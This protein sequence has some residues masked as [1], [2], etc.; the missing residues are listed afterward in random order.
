M[1]HVIPSLSPRDGGPSEAV[2]RMTSEL[3][4]GGVDVLVA[5]TDAD[6]A[7]RLPVRLGSVERRDGIPAI[8]FP[9]RFPGSFKYSGGLRRWLSEH[10]ADFDAVHVHAVFS[11]SSL[12]AGRACRR[13]GVPYLVRPLGSLEAWSLRQK[14]VRKRFALAL[15]VRRLLAGAAAVHYTTGRERRESE[16]ALRL[17]NGIV[18]PLGIERA[19]ARADGAREG[20]PYVL[21]LSRLHPKK[22][23]EILIDAFETISAE[24]RFRDWTL[25]IAGDGDP[26]YAASLR[27]RAA[28]TSGRDRVHFAGWLSGEEKWR[29]VAQADL[30][31][32]PSAEEN[33]GLAVLE[34]MGAGVPVAVS[35]G[36]D[37]AEEVRS[38]EAGWVFERSAPSLVWTLRQALSRPAERRRRGLRGRG[39]VERS[40]LWPEIANRLVETYRSIR[41]TGRPPQDLAGSPAGGAS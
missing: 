36:V 41:E 31:V 23:V 19:E 3:Q 11:H 38:A 33:F 5:A 7:G 17:S 29:V 25:V 30:M 16:R 4:R 28:A 21:F 18:V 27:R 32:L 24:T 20:A 37:L 22:G 26:R 8:F 1:L 35:D 40:Y 15:G 14:P 13:R 6:G 39:L 34:A 12:A 9:R 2:L 10:V